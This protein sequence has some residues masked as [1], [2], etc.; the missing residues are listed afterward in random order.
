MKK[1]TKN[2]IFKF[3]INQ[4]G[5]AIIYIKI[6]GDINKINSIFI[7]DFCESVQLI[8]NNN[9]IKAAILISKNKN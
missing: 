4:L 9:N 3:E 1:I 8:K 2:K 6:P 7:S 5:I